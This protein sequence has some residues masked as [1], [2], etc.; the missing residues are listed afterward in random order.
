M[1][2]QKKEIIEATQWWVNGDHPEDD[3][4]V[5]GDSR[6]GPYQGEGKVVR[7]YQSPER[8]GLEECKVCGKI[9]LQHG[10][11]DFG[12]KSGNLVCPGDY[13]VTT[14]AGYHKESKGYFEENYEVVG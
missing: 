12:N 9:K 1:K 8:D 2:Y 13:V 5:V 3:N 10:W 4:L 7:Y 11:I 14:S 6:L